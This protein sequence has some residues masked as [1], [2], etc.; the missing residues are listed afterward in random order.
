MGMVIEIFLVIYLL[1]VGQAEKVNKHI[2]LS[3]LQ[4]NNCIKLTIND[5]KGT[6]GVVLI[7]V[8]ENE[9]GYPDQ[10][11]FNYT[12]AK[13]TLKNG[14]LRL[15]IPIKNAG[16]EI[17]ISVL[18]DENMNGKM[19]YKFLIMPEEGFGFSNNPK[20]TSRKAPAFTVTSFRFKGGERR[21]E[22]N[23]VYM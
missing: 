2:L 1:N 18:D 14:R 7:G 15:N 17:S 19:D 21:V 5:L 12:L 9:T 16:G 13:D 20:I 6:K 22:I 11:S 3:E 8:F 10:P 4:V 23:M